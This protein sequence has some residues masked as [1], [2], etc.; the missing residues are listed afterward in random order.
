MATVAITAADLAI[1]T[2]SANLGVFGANTNTAG[3]ANS[4]GG[5]AVATATADGWTV[6]APTGR[7]LADGTLLLILST[8][9]TGDT[10]TMAVGARPPSMRAGLAA[11]TYVVAANNS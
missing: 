1:E 2:A 5:S 8:D 4:T 7:S 3:A 11:T 9:A 10:F 6:S